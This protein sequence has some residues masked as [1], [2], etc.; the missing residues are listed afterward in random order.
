M[1]ISL[2]FD[3]ISKSIKVYSVGYKNKKIIDATFNKLH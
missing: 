3:I 2:K 1:L